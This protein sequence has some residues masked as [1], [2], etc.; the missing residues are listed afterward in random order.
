MKVK[1]K[2]R[3]RLSFNKIICFLKKLPVE[4]LKVLIL[5]ALLAVV[6]ATS[7]PANPDFYPTYDVPAPVFAAP[8]YQPKVEARYNITQ[9]K[10][11]QLYITRF[12]L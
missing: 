6:S 12:I 2:K 4:Y 10:F 3:Q 9:F 8:A 7:P 5:V 1:L 11:D